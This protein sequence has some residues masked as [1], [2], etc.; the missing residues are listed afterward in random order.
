MRERETE[1][2]KQTE[3]NKLKLFDMFHRACTHSISSQ[4]Q[5]NCSRAKTLG[6]TIGWGGKEM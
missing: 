5:V 2:E 1:R 4:E 3:G 6:E